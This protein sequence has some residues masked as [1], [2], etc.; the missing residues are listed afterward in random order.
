MNI[1]NRIKYAT[2]I[3]LYNSCYRGE[4]YYYKGREW[5][6]N[7]SEMIIFL[8]E[9]KSFRVIGGYKH[10]LTDEEPVNS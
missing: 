3:W 9:I 4:K 1:K 10:V 7:R 8:T 2:I 5:L 6:I